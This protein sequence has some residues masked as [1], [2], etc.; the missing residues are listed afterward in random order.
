MRW[1]RLIATIGVA[2]GSAF[3][4][5]D[6]AQNLLEQCEVQSQAWY[7]RLLILALLFV[8]HGWILSA[9]AITVTRLDPFAQGLL[10]RL[11]ALAGVVAVAV[12]VG[13]SM[14]IVDPV[15]SF[16]IAAPCSA[17]EACIQPGFAH[18]LSQGARAAVTWS[19]TPMAVF[20]IQLFTIGALFV[21]GVAHHERSTS[22]RL[23][24]A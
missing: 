23:G 21:Q 24:V 19:N 17:L 3:A 8:L 7:A 12:M 4:V 10:K 5:I 6:E 22:A 9:G 20:M 13:F 2:S 15:L 11:A 16:L 18:S 1:S 14:N